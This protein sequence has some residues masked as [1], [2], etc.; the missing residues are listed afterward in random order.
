MESFRSVVFGNLS[1]VFLRWLT[2]QSTRTTPTTRHKEGET[3]YQLRACFTKEISYARS[4]L[5]IYRRIS[6]YCIH[7]HT[8]TLIQSIFFFHVGRR[9]L[10]W[11]QIRDLKVEPNQS[12]F[13]R[14]FLFVHSIVCAVCF[15]VILDF[16]LVLSCLGVY[17]LHFTYSIHF[18]YMEFFIRFFIIH[19]LFRMHIFI[20]RTSYS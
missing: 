20:S 11:W 17:S 6:C 5:G 9:L 14:S 16:Y 19:E 7:T 18:P 8:H 3:F 15:G 2:F 10:S 13:A 1:F 4:N 12:Y